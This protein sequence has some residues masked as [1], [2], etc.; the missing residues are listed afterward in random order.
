MI[1]TN[2]YLTENELQTLHKRFG[3]LSAPRLANILEH[4]GYNNIQYR[5]ILDYITKYCTRCQ[6]FGRVLLQF[7]FTFRDDNIDFNY[8]IYID[9]IY[10][11]SSPVLYIVDEATRF[12]AAYWLQNIMS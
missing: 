5:Q 11:D 8:S 4:T 1:S 7:K 9:I 3:H 6:K 10:I 2:C 12:Q